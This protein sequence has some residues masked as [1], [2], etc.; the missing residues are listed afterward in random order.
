ML[1]QVFANLID[2]AVKYT[3]HTSEARIEIGAFSRDS[4]IVYYVRDNGVG[5]DMAYAAKVFV[6]FQR[7]HKPGDY[8]GSGIGL[9]IVDRIIRRHGG[10]I[11]VESEPGKG[12][13]F[14]FTVGGSPGGSL[15]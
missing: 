13:S 14:Y 1:R 2:N 15:S 3:R 11:W 5:F 8:E 12:S 7:L 10:E 6:P 4:R 9:A